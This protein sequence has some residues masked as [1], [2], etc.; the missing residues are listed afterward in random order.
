MVGDVTFQLLSRLGVRKIET[1]SKM[2]VDVFS[3]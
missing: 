3:N 2:P 1:L